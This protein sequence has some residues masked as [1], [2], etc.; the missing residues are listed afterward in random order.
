MFEGV[1]GP[2]AYAAMSLPLD[3]A[4]PRAGDGATTG[5]SRSSG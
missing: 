3:G 4:A 2:P 5:A 1:A